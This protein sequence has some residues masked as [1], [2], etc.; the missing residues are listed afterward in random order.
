MKNKFKK[1]GFTLLESLVAVVIFSLA[2]GLALSGYV[3]T[4]KKVNSSEAQ[5]RLNR[6]VQLAMAMLENDLLYSSL[7]YIVGYPKDAGSYT[8]ISF[9]LLKRGNSNPSMDGDDKIVWEETVV[10]HVRPG[11]PYELVRT[12]FPTRDNSLTDAERQLQLDNVVSNGLDVAATSKVIFRNMMTWAITPNAGVYDAYFPTEKIETVSLGYARLSSGMNHFTFSALESNPL[13]SGNKIGIDKLYVSPSH[14][15]R[16]AEDQVASFGSYTKEE[17][18]VTYGGRH[19]L[20]SDGSKFTLDMENDR[21]EETDFT[22]DYTFQLDGCNILY[23]NFDYVVR[24]NGMDDTWTAKTQTQDQNNTLPASWDCRPATPGNPRYMVR[25][26]IDG[27]RSTMKGNECKFTF[28]ASDAQALHIRSAWFGESASSNNP[29]MNYRPGAMDATTNQ[30]TFNYITSHN[31][32]VVIPAST[33]IESEWL[34]HEFDPNKN[35]LISFE[36][37]KTPL[38][39]APKFWRNH[40]DDGA[41]NLVFD[42][43]VYTTYICTSGLY[44]VEANTW[45]DKFAYQEERYRD[46]AAFPVPNPLPDGMVTNPTQSNEFTAAGI[47]SIFVSY[48]S[49]GSYIS[50]ICDRGTD[51]LSDVKSATVTAHY[52][53]NPPKT[54]GSIEYRSYDDEVEFFNPNNNADWAGLMP[55]KRYIQFKVTMIS[56]PAT[57]YGANLHSDTPLINDIGMGWDCREKIVEIGGVF[58]KGPEY[59]IVTVL[60]NGE[61]L[62]ASLAIDLEIYEEIGAGK[63]QTSKI[64]AGKKTSIVPRNSGL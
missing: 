61:P 54:T 34:S 36:I 63:G 48:P 18:T 2:F 19:Q 44:N 51:Y 8:A 16:E 6:D 25:T 5:T 20:V 13:S 58:T 56:V 33:S 64:T 45:D 46:P 12:V 28:R 17:K 31:P 30:I 10:Y 52:T 23:T 1:T 42:D 43:T 62:K 55:D 15:S 60:V 50:P 3:H 7:D 21:W 59:G 14:L 49:S 35:Y 47:E 22:G 41:G 4:V 11:T 57:P 53:I 40:K 27:S 24:L 9:P 32:E 38:K 37:A 39:A 26:L 29:S